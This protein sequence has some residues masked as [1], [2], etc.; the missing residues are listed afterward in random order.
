MHNQDPLFLEKK[1][2]SFCKFIKSGKCTR[3]FLNNA[4]DVLG[5][6][7]PIPSYLQICHKDLEFPKISVG[8]MRPSSLLLFGLQFFYVLGTFGCTAAE[9]VG[10]KTETNLASQAMVENGS[11]I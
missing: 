9:V 3:T 5:G 8:E 10:K 4:G 11:L 1:K 6:T 2:F 7:N